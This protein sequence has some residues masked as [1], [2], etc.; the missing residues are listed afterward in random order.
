MDV[1]NFFGV[2]SSVW[3]RKEGNEP[4]RQAFFQLGWGV[5]TSVVGVACT[6]RAAGRAGGAFSL[7]KGETRVQGGAR[8]GWIGA[9]REI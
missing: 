9:R 1:V 3:Q 7:A 6:A 5:P 2:E 8:N 4:A